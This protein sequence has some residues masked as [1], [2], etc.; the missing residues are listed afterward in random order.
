MWKSIGWARPALQ[1][2]SYFL[3][4]QHWPAESTINPQADIAS[5]RTTR[6][7]QTRTYTMLS[8]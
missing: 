5:A 8:G 6:G 2:N 7:K 1:A 4:D 3:V